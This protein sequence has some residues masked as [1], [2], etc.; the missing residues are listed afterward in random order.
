MVKLK[1][2]LKSTGR[3]HIIE[4]R[5][6]EANYQ[7]G[8]VVVYLIDRMGIDGKCRGQQFGSY[9]PVRIQLLQRRKYFPE[10][11][12]NILPARIQ[13]SLLRS[14]K[15]RDGLCNVNRFFA[16]DAHSFAEQ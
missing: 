4:H 11:L 9:S 3:L 7:V 15:G 13:G 1:R 5:A 12:I 10:R 14:D 16:K 8:L 2:T 6:E